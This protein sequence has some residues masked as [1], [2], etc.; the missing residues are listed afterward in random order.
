MNWWCNGVDITWNFLPLL[1]TKIKF[2]P[3][4]YWGTKRDFVCFGWHAYSRLNI[5]PTLFCY[6]EQHALVHLNHKLWTHNCDIHKI[7]ILPLLDDD[8]QVAKF[9]CG[10][11]NVEIC[12]V[13]IWK[14]KR[15]RKKSHIK[16]CNNSPSYMIGFQ[17]NRRCWSIQLEDPYS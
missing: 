10:K 4:W 14:K 8:D 15:K 17:W 11:K 12:E 9:Y 1:L 2:G 16:F 5:E 3:W 13:I 7:Q 6:L